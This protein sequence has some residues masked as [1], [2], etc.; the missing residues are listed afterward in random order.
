MP[1]KEFFFFLV[2]S[3]LLSECIILMV[4]S[5]HVDNLYNMSEIT[6]PRSQCYWSWSWWSGDPSYEE[7]SSSGSD[8]EKRLQHDKEH[9]C[10][11]C[12]EQVKSYIFNFLKSNN[13]HTYRRN[14]DQI[15][16]CWTH[17]RKILLAN[18]I[19][20]LIRSAKANNEICRASATDALRDL[21]L[22]N[23]NC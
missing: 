8:A 15:S 13:I 9:C 3:I 11:K 4:C 17:Y 1:S 14:S 20:K 7:V 6:R 5:G 19:E 23:Y 12:R 16:F 21:G 2:A 10:E 22:D 18:G